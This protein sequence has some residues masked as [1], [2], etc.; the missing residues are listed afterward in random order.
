M[1]KYKHIIKYNLIIYFVIYLAIAIWS[2]LD[3]QI[4]MDEL[5]NSLGGA[6]L[7]IIGIIPTGF[8]STLVLITLQKKY[9]TDKLYKPR[10]N[11]RYSITQGDLPAVVQHKFTSA[12]ST[13]KSLTPNILT[14]LTSL[15]ESQSKYADL[16][17]TIAGILKQKRNALAELNESALLYTH[18]KKVTDEILK[19][20]N[21]SD[22]EV[23]NHFKNDDNFK[24]HYLNI[25]DV[26]TALRSPLMVIIGLC[27]DVGKLDSPLYP[28]Q[29]SYLSDFGIRGRNLLA[30]L[31][32]TWLLPKDDYNDLFIVMANY[33]NYD[34]APKLLKD[35][36]LVVKSVNA[37]CL[38]VVLLH[39]HALELKN[40]LLDEEELDDNEPLDYVEPCL[41]LATEVLFT[42]STAAKTNESMVQ[43]EL[44][45][46]ELVEQFEQIITIEQILPPTNAP[47]CNL[48][49][50]EEL[51]S[52]EQ[53]ISN[54]LNTKRLHK[55]NSS[56]CKLPDDRMEVSNLFPSKTPSEP[57][58]KIQR[59]R[60]GDDQQI[61]KSLRQTY[62]ASKKR[63]TS[64]KSFSIHNHINKKPTEKSNEQ[65]ESI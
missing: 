54:V 5:I 52:H 17:L 41:Q 29:T 37:T 19:L 11:G 6:M 36:E 61:R 28:G 20:Q 10:S 44:Q 14:W 45:D 34:N 38:T 53:E 64:P 15:D 58:V 24:K 63:E 48:L 27:H 3:K 51:Q 57:S 50:D 60:I 49:T 39:C 47:A 16:F 18:S 43:P 55:Q 35:G 31:K 13:K 42:T 46:E 2:F 1:T 7:L 32:E 23:Q 22:V 25:R 8:A 65:T 56:R 59:S 21:L 62:Q 40:P 33:S 12:T 4:H 30:K 9:I 26:I